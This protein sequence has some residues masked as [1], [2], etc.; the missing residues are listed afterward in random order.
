MTYRFVSPT[1]AILPEATGILVGFVRDP[2]RFKLNEYCQLVNSPGTTGIYHEL[3]RD[4]PIRVVTDAEFAWED[5]DDSPTG[6][7]N[8]GNFQVQEFRCYRRA[9][10][11]V[12][13]EEA[14]EAFQKQGAFDPIAFESQSCASQAMVQR[15]KR[16][17][18]DLDAV[19]S[20]TGYTASATSLGGGKWDAGTSA[21]PYL[22]KGILEACRKINFATNGVVQMQDLVLILNPID[23]IKISASQEM[24][25]YIKSS[26]DAEKMITGELRPNQNQL[27][28]LPSRIHGL[29]VVVEDA[30][31]VSTRNNADGTAGTRAYLKAEDSA[32]IV[33][34][35]GGVDAPYGA[36]SFSTEQL[37]YHKYEMAVEM[38][39]GSDNWHKR[40]EGRVLDYYATK[41]VALPTGYFVSDIITA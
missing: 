17:M 11:F 39:S 3:D 37:F 10:P 32:I 9:I 1:N 29:K 20:W 21:N 22:K 40:H 2:K 36:K 15:T 12:V 25:D 28:G 27:W 16:V 13:G 5:G 24:H 14:A 7:T 19:G 26:P 35:A 23:A 31:Y 41:L 8:K 38:R 18:A 6:N 4:R 33:S 34:R 30:V